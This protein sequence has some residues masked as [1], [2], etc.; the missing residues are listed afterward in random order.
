MLRGLAHR[1]D[2]GEGV[3]TSPAPFFLPCASLQVSRLLASGAVK[4]SDPAGDPDAG[5]ILLFEA[6]ASGSIVRT[7]AMSAL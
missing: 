5:N 3:N 2:G 4:P 6:A 1:P 7:A